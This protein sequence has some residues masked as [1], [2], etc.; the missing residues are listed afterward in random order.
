MPVQLTT[1]MSPYAV[2]RELFLNTFI[3]GRKFLVRDD[4]SCLHT[5]GDVSVVPSMEEMAGCLVTVYDAKLERDG[6]PI[7][8]VAEAHGW[9]WSPSM[10]VDPYAQSASCD[11]EIDND[12]L[13]ELLA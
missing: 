9:N 8:R 6:F 2:D 10:F 13:M 12:A 11:H 1:R 7:I 3:P 5:Y 4:L